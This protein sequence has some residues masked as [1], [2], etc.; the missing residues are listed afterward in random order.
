MTKPTTEATATIA[1]NA[2]A[3]APA[4]AVI[5]GQTE[6]DSL[7]AAKSD[8]QIVYVNV[9]DIQVGFDVRE[10]DTEDER[11]D[12]FADLFG[13]SYATVPELYVE[14]LDKPYYDAIHKRT[15]SPGEYMVIDGRNRLAGA[16]KAKV[17]QVRCRI[18]LGLTEEERCFIGI[19]ANM[20]G[21]KPENKKDLFVTFKRLAFPVSE[22][23]QNIPLKVIRARYA[24]LV[25]PSLLRH[26]IRWV[27][28][29]LDDWKMPRATSAVIAGTM[30]EAQAAKEWG[31]TPKKIH[32]A[33][34]E[35][36]HPGRTKK[37]RSDWAVSAE[38]AVGKHFQA[39]RASLSRMVSKCGD[40]YHDS[41]V[42][43]PE[44]TSLMDKMEREAKSLASKTAEMRKKFNGQVLFKI[45]EKPQC[46]EDA[47]APK[48][49]AAGQGR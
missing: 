15:Y 3:P 36:L 5:K 29:D 44:A 35:R 24:S 1:K 43:I 28:S 12:F 11:V 19:G 31:F 34:Q 10:T 13:K 42:T 7:I 18:F 8:G 9:G 21:P 17:K 49:K 48:T 32:E 2:P 6:L 4:T 30:T 39:L 23:G 33:V 45:P 38:G 26:V 20:F 22:G 25:P 14:L 16:V 37:D 40:L 41:L 46:K 27:D 47:D